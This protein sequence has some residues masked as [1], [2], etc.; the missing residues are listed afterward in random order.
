MASFPGK[1]SSSVFSDDDELDIFRS[2][3]PR[4]SFPHFI[5]STTEHDIITLP[6]APRSLENMSYNS[7]PQVENCFSPRCYNMWDFPPN[8]D[9]FWK[10]PK[11]SEIM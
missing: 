10:I 3:I 1:S 5:A 11:N 9:A 8:K 4:R 7:R 6:P 2:E